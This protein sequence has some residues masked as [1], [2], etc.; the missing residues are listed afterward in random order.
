ML[1]KVFHFYGDLGKKYDDLLSSYQYNN[2]LVGQAVLGPYSP[3]SMVLGANQFDYRGNV[4]RQERK[5]M[6]MVQKVITANDQPAGGR[7]VVSVAGARGLASGTF[8][9]DI[10]SKNIVSPFPPLQGSQL[11][12]T[13]AVMNGK[14]DRFDDKYYNQVDGGGASKTENR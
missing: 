13:V 10:A 14:F 5:Q 4:F 11:D 8:I 6:A 7:G 12:Q 9:A 3:G 2:T 1:P